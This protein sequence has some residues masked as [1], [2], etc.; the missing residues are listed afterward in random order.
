MSSAEHIRHKGF[1][2]YH[3]DDQA[4]VDEFIRT[5]DHRR[6]TFIARAVG[7]DQTS[8]HL[9]DS[10]NP[11]YIMRR[12]RKLY[13]KDSTVTI[14]VI[15]ENTWTRKFVDW[16][17]AASLRQGPVAGKPNGLVA[18]L[19]PKLKDAILPD[20]LWVNLLSGYARFYP[21]PRSQAE[22][23]KWIEEAF[24]ARTQRA[25]KIKNSSPIQRCNLSPNWPEDRPHIAPTSS[26]LLAPDY[27]KE[28]SSGMDRLIKLG[29]I[30]L[31]TFLIIKAYK[32]KKPIQN[33]YSDLWKWGVPGMDSQEWS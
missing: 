27:L 1:I 3:H 4:E 31:G 29:V 18:I 10:G 21:Y 22:L 2:P 7:S 8:Q 28:S 23:A 16:E 19:S 17:L 12:I 33:P 11:E 30:A 15:G 9:I 25:N 14:V 26:G 24:Q 32:N 5:F 6:D 20:R 13:I